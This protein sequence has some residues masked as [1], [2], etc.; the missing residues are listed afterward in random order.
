MILQ[1]YESSA[2]ELN[3]SL[4]ALI[5][6]IS[7]YWFNLI[8]NKLIFKLL[9]FAFWKNLWD[10]TV[11]LILQKRDAFALTHV[12]FDNLKLNFL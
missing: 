1:R 5:S 12:N 8:W 6:F 11:F 9:E 10:F 3:S 4:N 2:V 7:I